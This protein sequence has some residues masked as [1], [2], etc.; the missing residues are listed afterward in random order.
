[1]AV[2]TPIGVLSFA[3]IFQPKP[4]AQ[5]REPEYSCVLIFDAEA[6]KSPAYKDLKAAVLEAIAD[7]WGEAKSKDPNFIKKL[8]LPFRDAGEKDYAGYGEGKTF[9][10]P[11]SKLK[12]G[13]VD[14][15]R[16]DILTASDVWAGQLARAFVNPFAWENSGKLG[17]SFAL[18]HVQ[19]TKQDM[20]RLDGRKDAKAAFDDDLPAD[21]GE[22]EGADPF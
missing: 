10:Q 2:K 20:P 7:K 19:I 12:P 18:E 9:I 21:A 1:M 6:Q 8:Q 11:W 15:D 14:R 22:L 17:V 3:H 4:R 13:I 16:N 5:G